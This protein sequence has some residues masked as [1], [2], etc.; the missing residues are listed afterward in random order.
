MAKLLIE[1]VLP[2]GETFGDADGIALWKIR[3]CNYFKKNHINDGAR[4]AQWSHP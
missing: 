3:I 4:K 2:K 1:L